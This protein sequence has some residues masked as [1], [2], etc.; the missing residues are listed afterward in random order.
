MET[1]PFGIFCGMGSSIFVPLFEPLPL[2]TVKVTADEVALAPLLSVARALIVC[3][4]A[5]R[6]TSIIYGE[7]VTMPKEVGP[8][9]NS[10]FEIV[11]PVAEA[12]AVSVTVP[13][14]EI[15]VL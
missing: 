9:K 3:V 8:S 12:L 4:P 6:F 15:V 1:S 13:A 10:T 11:A 5:A 14:A 7:L 2:P